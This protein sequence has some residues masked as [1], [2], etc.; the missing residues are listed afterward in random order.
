MALFVKFFCGNGFLSKAAKA[1]M[2]HGFGPLRDPLP[3]GWRLGGEACGRP[4]S[5][6]SQSRKEV[7]WVP[8]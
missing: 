4:A 3:C 8:T 2:W 7:A 5:G 6:E 1:A